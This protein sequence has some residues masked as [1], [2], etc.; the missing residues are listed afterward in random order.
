MGKALDEISNYGATRLFGELAFTICQDMGLLG[1]LGHLDTTSFSLQGKYE[2][3]ETGVVEVRHGFSKDHRKDLKQ[4]VLSLI[5][6]GPANLPVWME[7]QNGNSSDKKSFHETI[8]R[9]Q[10]FTKELGQNHTF[11]WIADS[12]LYTADR[13]LKHDSIEWISRVPEAIKEAKNLVEQSDKSFDWHDEGKGY[14]WS[15][16]KSNYGKIEQRWIVVSSEQTYNREKKTLERK[17]EELGKACW[18]LSNKLF[19][20][21]EDAAKGVAA[22]QKKYKYHVISYEIVATEKYSKSGRPGKDSSKKIKGYQVKWE[23]LSNKE[24]QEKALTAKGRFILATNNL[25]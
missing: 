11:C 3:E 18:H 2:T 23:V 15:E 5:M 20:C 14:R 16:V 4:V 9:V 1:E 24:A 25:N 10:S 21:P 6:T 22:L 17:E 13:L 12:A 8:K 7:P 19:N